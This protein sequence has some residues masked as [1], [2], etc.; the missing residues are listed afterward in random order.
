M[1]WQVAFWVSVWINISALVSAFASALTVKSYRERCED[2]LSSM[3]RHMR[4][5]AADNLYMVSLV[6][7]VMED[8]ARVDPSKADMIELGL[9]ELGHIE[10]QFREIA[11]AGDPWKGEAPKLEKG[12]ADA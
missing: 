1:N 10:S 7:P 6:R 4:T 2:T 9:I 11:D 8:L 3:W 12:S 5:N